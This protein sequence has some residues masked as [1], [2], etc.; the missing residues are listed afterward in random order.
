MTDIEQIVNRFSTYICLM[1]QDNKQLVYPTQVRHRTC[2]YLMQALLSDRRSA[3][4]IDFW[5]RYFLHSL[6]S[7]LIVYRLIC[8]TNIPKNKTSEYY[9]FLQACSDFMLLYLQPVCWETALNLDKVIS[10]TSVQKTGYSLEDY[11]MIACENSLDFMNFLSGFDFE[12]STSL[13]GF[14]K[15]ILQRKTRNQIVRELNNKAIKFTGYGLLKYTSSSAFEE[16]LLNYGILSE[17]LY[18]YKLVHQAFKDYSNC[19]LGSLMASNFS[20]NKIIL[21]SKAVDVISKRVLSQVK[22]L[23]LEMNSFGNSD[24]INCLEISV[25]AVQSRQ[26][27]MT[28]SFDSL[29]QNLA[30]MPSY[31][32]PFVDSEMIQQDDVDD[33]NVDVVLSAFKSLEAV[34]QS[35]LILWL[36]LEINQVDFAD[37]LNVRKQ[38]QV[39]RL[40]QRYQRIMLREVV[41]IATQQGVI[42][43]S[44]MPNIN[45]LCQEKLWLIKDYL[46]NYSYRQLSGILEN[47]VLNQL[48]ADER[49]S[50]NR[51]ISSLDLYMSPISDRDIESI[52]SLEELIKL[53]S[54]FRAGIEKMLEFRLSSFKSIDTRIRSFLITWLVKNQAVLQRG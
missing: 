29:P 26:N 1:E 51:W 13:H 19:Q 22:R 3:G 42:Q 17:N 34:G 24:V 43:S 49:M 4:N 31:H 6:L 46:K 16:A 50:L 47:V 53:E 37:V 8:K 10:R 36:G 48:E 25:K 35:S 27:R 11:F 33:V 30:E 12:F 15:S 28:I 40:F 5:A 21:D 9:I 54:M 18:K 20:S 38:Y 32:E 45:S 44:E 2:Q 39:A 7:R 52:N 41:R 14:S 23:R